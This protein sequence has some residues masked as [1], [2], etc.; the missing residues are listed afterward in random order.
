[1]SGASTRL[2]QESLADIQGFITSGYGHLRSAAYLFVQMNDAAGARHWIR[3]LVPSLSS[4]R[5]WS[6]DAGGRKAKP[7]SAVNVAFTAPGLAAC[8]L[9]ASALCTF[10]AEFQEGV[11]VP[12]RSRILGDTEASAPASW[13]I[14]GPGREFDALVL[15]HAEDEPDRK[16]VV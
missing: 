7:A 4:S 9:P 10:P 13:E 3:A 12:H 8:G 2:T 16:S 1:M 5:Q 6:V 14:G 15:M 11:A